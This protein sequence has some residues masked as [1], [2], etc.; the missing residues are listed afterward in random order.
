VA[1]VFKLA[2][3]AAQKR[4]PC[5]ILA[6]QHLKGESFF[7]FRPSTPS[8]PLQKAMDILNWT[9]KH[10]DPPIDPERVY[11]VGPS[12]GGMGA[13]E[14]SAKYP[15]VFAAVV[16][17]ATGYF[18]YMLTEYNVNRYWCLFNRADLAR[19][20]ECNRSFQKKVVELGGE[21]RAGEYQG[22]GH[23]AWTA[24]FSEP[25]LWEWVFSQ[26]RSRTKPLGQVAAPAGADAP[27]AVIA[28]RA[29]ASM[30]AEGFNK[31]EDAVDG[32]LKS[33][34]VSI[35][36]APA[37]GYWQVEFD[38]P[39]SRKR[40]RLITGDPQGKYVA[41]GCAV[42]VSPDGKLFMAAGTVRG[43][44][45]VIRPSLP[46]RVLRVAVPPGFKQPLAIRELSVDDR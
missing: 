32:L 25:R 33:A 22:D 8:E 23:D 27:G 35:D 26:N 37:E 43:A 2:D 34:F 29:S 24:A 45:T 18:P 28:M 4:Q 44:E 10:A 7:H 17:V 3:K 40:I 14:A 19:M 6:P 5:Y 31:A 13:F 16:A 12:S 42:T 21:F 36:P 46:V 11:V 9:L 30:E 15:G 1:G 39:V 41:K 20:A 38:P